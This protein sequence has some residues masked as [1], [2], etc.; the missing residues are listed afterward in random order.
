MELEYTEE[1]KLL[2][3]QY[4]SRERGG[5]RKE[6]YTGEYLRAS[7]SL[8]SGHQHSVFFPLILSHELK[9]QWAFWNVVSGA[10]RAS[11]D[12]VFVATHMRPVCVCVC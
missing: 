11:E 9:Q 8:S 6:K 1:H 3:A 5:V 12:K 7:S 4:E 10:D 2:G